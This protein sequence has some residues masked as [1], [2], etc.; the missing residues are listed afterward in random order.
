VHNPVGLHTNRLAL[1]AN[2]HLKMDK[3]IK[4]IGV[5]NMNFSDN[6]LLLELVRAQNRSNEIL[7]HIRWIVGFLTVVAVIAWFKFGH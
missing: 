1:A 7:S 3:K 4:V 6:E 5:N 2:S